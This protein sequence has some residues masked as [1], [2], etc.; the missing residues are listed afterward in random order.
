MN[1]QNRMGPRTLPW[2]TPALTGGGDE[3]VLLRATHSQQAWMKSV[4]Q[5]W[6]WPWIPKADSL[7]SKAGYR[8]HQ[9]L[10]IQYV[11]R[12]GPDLMSRIEGLHPFFGE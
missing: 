6:S 11:Q 12:D 5:E 9:K 1:I 2:G 10:E 7:E 8:L 4:I 3:R